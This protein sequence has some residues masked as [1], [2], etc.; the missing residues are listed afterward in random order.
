MEFIKIC[1]S[2]FGILS[3]SNLDS[4]LMSDIA[5]Y[6]TGE[7]GR[8]FLV[9]LLDHGIEFN[10]IIF[11]DS[12]FSGHI[13][14]S[15]IEYEVRKIEELEPHIGLNL[16]IASIELLD[17]IEN[18]FPIKAVKSFILSNELIHAASHL[19]KL[20]DFYLTDEEA[21]SSRGQ[22]LKML[23]YFTKP[24]D[25]HLLLSLIEL[26]SGRGEKQ[27]YQETIK[28]LQNTRVEN[29]SNSKKVWLDAIDERFD[30]II[31]GGVFDG[32]DSAF[33]LPYLSDKGTLKGFDL[34]FS[35]LSLGKYA[36]LE[37]ESRVQF[38]KRAL[39][40]EPGFVNILIDPNKKS[41]SHVSKTETQVKRHDFPEAWMI[42]STSLDSEFEQLSN[43][44]ILL[45]LDVEGAEQEILEGA[46]HFIG[47]NQIYGIISLY[48]KA[49]DLEQILTR[50]EKSENLNKIEIYCS[51]PTFIDWD[52]LVS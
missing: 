44:K 50:I 41:N 16:I 22:V 24:N 13:E 11:V 5:I 17:M 28:R 15:D 9:Y 42:P 18:S 35:P 36:W 10:S 23:S 6:G 46:Q 1:G 27:F 25:V 34:D 48:H 51:N 33:L 38:V 45:K 20:G 31:D 47:N 12:F 30:L 4:L 39:A 29:V 32:E 21:T 7:T 40:S 26:R 37:N 3:T 14:I 2:D 43:Q 52:L 8:E 19:S 49:S